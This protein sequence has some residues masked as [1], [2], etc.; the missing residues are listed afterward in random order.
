[1]LCQVLAAVAKGHTESVARLVQAGAR[2]LTVNDA[3]D[4]PL[5]LAAA[6]GNLPVVELL[7]PLPGAPALL[8]KKNVKGVQVSQ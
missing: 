7:L 2:H 1:M 5:A 8:K 3:G 4:S 6:G